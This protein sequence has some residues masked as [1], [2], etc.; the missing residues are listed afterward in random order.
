MIFVRGKVVRD[1]IG[2]CLVGSR[3]ASDKGL[4][5]AVDAATSLV[6]EGVTVV[7][8]LAKGIDTA[9]HT[10]ALENG[11]RTVAVIGTGV[12][13][14][15]P[16]ENAELQTR[17]AD[18]GLV[19]SQFWPGSG[20]TRSSFPMRN[21]TMS[22]YG[23]AT[24]V[25]EAGER[26][27]ARIQARQATEHG[28]PLILTSSVVQS[29]KWGRDLAHSAGDIHVVRD[30]DEMLEVVRELLNRRHCLD[31]LLESLQ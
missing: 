11:G 17:I 18:K 14:S 1:D 3:D 25:V 30:V 31:N 7:S 21:A 23:Q 16:P 13:K 19:L 24:V 26:S 9:A 5:F 22:A 20:P 29:T 4:R 15:Y 6:Q 28:R 12:D 27:G 10:T 2:V 8:G